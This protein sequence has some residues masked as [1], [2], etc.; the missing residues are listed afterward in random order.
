[1]AHSRGYKNI[2]SSRFCF[3]QLLRIRQQLREILHKINEKSPAACKEDLPH[4]DDI[5]KMKDKLF[6]LAKKKVNL[7]YAYH[8]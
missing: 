3:G 2:L 1:M 5:A 4:N 7:N 8:Y 6:D